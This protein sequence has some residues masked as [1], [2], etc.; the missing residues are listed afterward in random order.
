MDDEEFKRVVLERF[1]AVD[2]RLNA[3]VARLDQQDEAHDNLYGKVDRLQK[4]VTSL[5][6]TVE[7]ARWTC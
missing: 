1:D 7:Q 4:A 6:E 2:R 3:I 5:T